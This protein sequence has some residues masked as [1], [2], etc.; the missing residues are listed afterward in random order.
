VGAVGGW[1]EEADG[2]V[3]ELDAVD[4]EVDRQSGED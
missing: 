4:G 3:G 2:Q 1:G